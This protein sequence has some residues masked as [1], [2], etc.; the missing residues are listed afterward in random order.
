[1]RPDFLAGDPRLEPSRVVILQDGVRAPVRR[2]EP[3]SVRRE[4]G[5]PA[6]AVVVGSVARLA[7]QKRFDRLL[8]A[9]AAIPQPVHCVIAGEGRQRER[10]EAL[11]RELEMA[12][13]LHLLGFRDDVGDV[14][15]ALDLFVVSSDREGLA[16]AM[17]EAMAFGLPVVSTDVSG[18]REALEPDAGEPRPGIVVPVE[19]D[20]LRDALAGLVRDGD[21]RRAM[22]AAARERAER[23]FGWERFL[24]DWERLLA[25]RGG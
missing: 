4:L 9:L 2:A 21:A 11:A 14:L 1:M 17:L 19:E 6:D 25:E 3:G 10:L 15:D 22:G 12:D 23:R 13:R 7:S 16:N 24:D 18:A 20:A 5:I 8:R